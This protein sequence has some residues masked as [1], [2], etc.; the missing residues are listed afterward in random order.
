MS[1]KIEF[2]LSG[3]SITSDDVDDIYTD[4][5][6]WSLPWIFLLGTAWGG[7]L[8]SIFWLLA[9]YLAGVL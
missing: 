3:Q 8:T 7:L 6:P 9:L 2:L 4:D 1:E 5:D